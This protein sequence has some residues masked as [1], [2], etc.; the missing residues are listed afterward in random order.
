MGIFSSQHQNIMLMKN[1]RTY[2]LL[3]ML[4]VSQMTWAQGVAE[5]LMPDGS[6]VINTSRMGVSNY[7]LT[8][9]PGQEFT[10]HW[11]YW[12]TGTST[13]TGNFLT[14]S[15]PSWLTGVSPST[16]SSSSCTDI[17]PVGFSFKAPNTPGVY[18]YTVVMSGNNTWND[19]G[20][21]LIVT[22]SPD[23][24]TTF[25]TGTTT[26]IDTLINTWSYSGFSFSNNNCVSNYLGQ[27]HQ[28]IW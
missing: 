9:L 6:R 13:Q 11:Y 3:F 12:A 17:V 14:S 28:I 2:L 25:V 19:M 23:A 7:E 16:F 22:N 1:Q 4:L 27:T 8:L 24:D 5:P 20:I 18:T 10:G 26:T 15:T 21:T